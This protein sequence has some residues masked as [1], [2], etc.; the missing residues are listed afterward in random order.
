LL[1]RIEH[2]IDAG[3]GQI[4]KALVGVGNIAVVWGQSRKGIGKALSFRMK[5]DLG[6]KRTVIFFY[7]CPLFLSLRFC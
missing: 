3:I 2:F 1:I 7:F 5:R 6:A 4:K